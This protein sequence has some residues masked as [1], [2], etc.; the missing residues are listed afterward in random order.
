MPSQIEFYTSTNATPSVETQRGFIDRDGT[1]N[2]LSGGILETGAPIEGRRNAIVTTSTDGFVGNNTTPAT[3]IVPVQMSPRIRL[4]G[5]V[6]NT[7]G[8]GSPETSNWIIENLPTSGTTPTSLLKFGYS[9]NGGTYSYPMTLSNV[10]S[11]TV[12]GACSIGSS[13]Y[14][15]SGNGL[16]HN[17]ATYG[18]YLVGSATYGN[19]I[20]RNIA[21]AFTT[22]TINNVHASS[23]GKILSFQAVSVEKSYIHRDGVYAGAGIELPNII[24][25][26]ASAN[27]RNSHNAEATS[28]SA[29]Y[30]KVKTITLTH[31]LLGQQR[32]IFEIKT[33]D[34]VTPEIAYGK[35]YRNGVALGTEQSD[36][37][38]SYVSKSEDITQT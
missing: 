21:D 31:G 22:Q 14:V 12:L 37:T 8:A 20:D 7:S 15:P 24:K 3:S 19:V 25:K 34:S 30:V 27:I 1:L 6:W 28:T 36:L 32:F 10:G 5:G 33:S 11:I 23:T 9:R 35:I 4:S 29:T 2:W 18:E 16:R 13:Y 17:I 26:V 38:G